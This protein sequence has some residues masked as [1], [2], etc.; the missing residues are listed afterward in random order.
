VRLACVALL[1]APCLGHADWY[2]G[3]RAAMKQVDRR[4][5]P[6][7]LPEPGAASQVFR[8]VHADTSRIAGDE[9][10]AAGA[11]RFEFK[12]YQVWADAIKGNRR[13]QVF[14]LDGNV[15]LEGKSETVTGEFVRVDF[16]EDTFEYRS[17]RARLGPGRL[18]AALSGDL[19]VRSQSGAGTPSDFTSED[20]LATTCDLEHP[21][22]GVRARSVRVLPGKRAIM[23]DAKLQAL[24][25]T[26]VGVPYLVLPLV[27]DGTKNLPEVGQNPQEGYYLKTRISTP[28]PGE[29]YFDTRVDLMTRLGVGLGVD[30][31]YT[32]RG[33]DGDARVYTILGPERSFTAFLG[34]LQRLAGGNLAV[35]ANLQRSDYRTAPS[36]TL[37]NMVG[38]WSLMGPT[39]STRLSYS[40]SDSASAGFRSVNQSGSVSDSRS[41][42]RLQLSGDVTLS[43]YDTQATGAA[44]VRSERLDTSF[45]ARR[46]W[47]EATMELLYRRSVPVGRGRAFT[48]QGDQTPL[49]TLRSSSGRL[50]GERAGREWPLELE[51]SVGELSDA[52]L[53][54]PVTR[55]HFAAQHR[56]SFEPS[57]RLEVEYSGEFRQSLYS[58]DTAQYVTAYGGRAE[59]N[60]QGRSSLAARYSWLRGFGFTPLQLDRSGRNDG[61]DLE[62]AYEPS[63]TLRLSGVTGYDVLLASQG[64]APWQQVWLRADWRPS[65]STSVQASAVY[66][67]FSQAWSV[68]R[69]DSRFKLGGAECAAGLSYDGV[70]QKVG[71]INLLVE[72]F[73]AGRVSANAVVD[74]NGFTNQVVAQHYQLLYDLHCVEAVFEVIENNT[75]FNSGRTFGFYLRIKALPSFSPFGTGTR[76][77]GI[78][79]GRG[80]GF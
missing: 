35:T 14:E 24:G 54:R 1:L 53:A 43:R 80:A 23:R 70:R 51:A 69:L 29:S 31:D 76:G 27:E 36:A 38:A 58:D 3:F 63:P 17:G 9:V 60:W 52:S 30:V 32:G 20:G 22:W 48:N 19:Y 2:H 78:G 21:H 6:P 4:G 41:L 34:H 77:Q 50:W 8:L 25:R 7:Q 40:R 33:V 47:R 26:I 15:R 62:L 49:L 75:G 18:E 44:G 13:T 57:P 73:R 42:G 46:D 67:T 66:D 45:S 64:E 61:F 79:R 56:R 55:M 65:E 12:G 10:E 5:G 37:W 39:G 16:L 74:F 72:G 28:L 59:W 11:V 68:L 71:S